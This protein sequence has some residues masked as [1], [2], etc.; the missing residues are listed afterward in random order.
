[1]HPSLHP[2][3][4]AIKLKL[5]MK[6]LSFIDLN[7]DGKIQWWEATMFVMGGVSVYFAIDYLF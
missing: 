2:R 5:F 3:K 4:R 7:K 1:M 6:L